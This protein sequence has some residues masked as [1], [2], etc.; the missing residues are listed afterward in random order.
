MAALSLLALPW[1]RGA[2]VAG[3]AVQ[4]LNVVLNIDMPSTDAAPS[5][6]RGGDSMQTLR[7][8]AGDI[9][10]EGVSCLQ[11]LRGEGWQ[12]T[13][14]DTPPPCSASCVTRALESSTS[15]EPAVH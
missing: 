11:Q 1:Q 2:S 13:W 9:C 6:W 3:Y 15:S 8:D 7:A 5:G 4:A 12:A 14:A 10:A